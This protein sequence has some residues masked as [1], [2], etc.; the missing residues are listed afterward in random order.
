V[1]LVS[2][3]LKY[4]TH[5]LDASEKWAEGTAREIVNAGQAPQP[6][7]LTVPPFSLLTIVPILRKKV[8]KC[9]VILDYRDPWQH[10]LDKRKSPSGF[11]KTEQVALELC[12]EAW[13]T[14]EEHK[15]SMQEI[16]GVAPAKVFV[17]PNGFDMEDYQ[18]VNVV[19]G[20]TGSAIYLGQMMEQRVF[21]LLDVLK[22]LE[23]SDLTELKQCF[24]I[25]AYTDSTIPVQKFSA[26]QLALFQKYVELKIPVPAHKVPEILKDYRYG[27]TI[28][29]SGFNLTIPVKNFEYLALGKQIL[30]F[31]PVTSFHEELGKSGHF[32]SSFNPNEVL[33]LFQ[34]FNLQVEQEF[35]LQPPSKYD[36]ANI[37]QEV[38]ARISYWN[39]EDNLLQ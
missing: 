17:I 12:Q 31:G 21:H 3:L 38:S 9:P 30:S 25:A 18:Q 7:V 6:I 28:G 33:N 35:Q 16:Y 22:V 5:S 36:I 13:V 11:L 2:R 39:R 20:A 4:T 15:A 27:L 37:S 8:P 14:T 32:I 26:D 10:S 1:K 24:R 34:K 23:D 19:R 29:V